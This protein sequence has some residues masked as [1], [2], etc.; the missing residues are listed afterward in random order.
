MFQ[1][2]SQNSY[3]STAIAVGLV[4]TLAV[5]VATLVDAVSGMQ[6]YL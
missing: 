1:R 6:S 3:Y 5:V 2:K 4:V